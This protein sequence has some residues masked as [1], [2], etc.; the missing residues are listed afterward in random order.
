MKGKTI[1]AITILW[2][3]GG[4][5]FGQKTA[6]FTDTERH[7]NKG[8]E[9]YEKGLFGAAIHEF[10]MALNKDFPIHREASSV[11]EAKAKLMKAACLI[12][13]DIPEGE[14]MMAVFLRENPNNPVATQ[15][16]IEIGNYHYNSG[17]YDKAI[18]FYEMVR[19][20][21]LPDEM[22]AEVIFKTGYSYFALQDFQ[23]AMSAFSPL[24]EERTMYYYPANYYYAMSAWYTGQR[25]RALEHFERV[26]S[27]AYYNQLV[28]YYI[29]AI[30]FTEEDFD[31]V[32]DFLTPY[33]EEGDIRYSD[34]IHLVL[35]QSWFEREN[36]ENAATHLKK[37]VEAGN[38][39]DRG[40]RYQLGY[41]LHQTDRCKEAIP[42]LQFLTT[43][44]DA[45]SQNANFFLA[46]CYLNVGDKES[47]RNAFANAVRIDYDKDVVE[48]A[49][50]N[51]GKLSAEMG[52]DRQAVNSL[53]KF[54]PGSVFYGQ[55][56]E[57][58]GDILLNT[59]DYARAIEIIEEIDSPTPAIRRAYQKVTFRRGV[60]LMN[61]N[62]PDVARDHFDKS[63]VNPI[64]SG[65]RAQALFWKAE[66]SHRDNNY[67]Q[68]IE[69]LNQYFTVARTAGQL[70]EE[71]SVP[72][73]NY[74][75]GYNYLKLERH[76][77]ALGFF[78]DAVSD[79]R[80]NTVNFTS[81][82]IRNLILSD[83][84]MRAGDC[85]FKNNRYNQALRFYNDAIEM[86]HS[87]YD[88]AIFQK[89]LIMGLTEKP[90]EK[91]VLLEDLLT[92]H[93]ESAYAD[94]AL[95][96][97]A[98]TFQELNR[99]TEAVRALERLVQDYG[100]TSILVNQA[101]LRLG[102]IHYNEGDLSTATHHYK[103]VFDSN[104]DKREAQ[105]ALAALEEIYVNDMGR[106]EDYFRL[107]EEIGLID[108]SDF[109]RDSLT[110]RAAEI[111][112]ME[113]NCERAIASYT[114]YIEQFPRGVFL[115][116]AYYNR[117]ECYSIQRRWD[118]ALNDYESVVAR[119]PG[120]YYARALNKAAT[121]SYH[122]ENDY[123]RAFSLYKDLLA[124]AQSGEQRFE[125]SLGA[126]RSAYR[127][128]HAEGVLEF[129]ERILEDERA[130]E[131]NK[132]SAHY[133]MG[134]INFD[135]KQY[136]RA[137]ENFNRVTRLTDNVYAAESRYKI[138]R[139]YLLQNEIELAEELARTAVQDNSNYPYWVAKSLVLL[140]DVLVIQGDNFNA[141][142]AL[143]A[144]VEHF[145]EDPE[146]VEEAREKL[147]RIEAKDRGESEDSS[148]ESEE[149]E[150]MPEEAIDED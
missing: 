147:R 133:Y 4:L 37:A 46:E 45:M 12:R 55:A 67:R 14:Q 132:A 83:A 72:V 30:Y 18:R 137:L 92:G 48:E 79:I 16:I 56:Q 34:D 148:R 59:R 35:G 108:F 17:D 126:L 118:R 127:A 93:P 128:R 134:K 124:A 1:L 41:S 24:L 116:Q 97:L 95:I 52:Y 86:G 42:H 9:Y 122:H 131:E 13:M 77:V 98:V 123:Q 109:A 69:E 101:H 142:A 38:E 26:E 100:E 44:S 145:D 31:G 80:L 90:F 75:Q 61:D 150:F 3:A 2:L 81:S 54:D 138:S 88:Y 87:G 27:S 129:G 141:R 121:I 140:A 119:G 66:L 15:G 47:A 65:I 7:F 111:Q 117:G 135:L 84:M 58:L 82:Y 136:S 103:A 104:P 5:V 21:D 143:S 106:P 89:A 130:S 8:L 73:A 76:E 125:A 60:Q 33:V 6:L 25:Q 85:L 39:Q 68:S 139:I 74:L 49:R 112:F 102:L 36:Y 23:P 10:R 28:P 62:D 114:N 40:I 105:D 53:V 78:Q 32:I 43:E 94:D 50:F 20:H 51:Y 71:T 146:I 63:L 113:G 57:V 115:V 149:E 107:V 110:F 29:G 120:T 70:P 64:E 11:V 96:Q 19:L 91:I 22:R 99:S 144:V